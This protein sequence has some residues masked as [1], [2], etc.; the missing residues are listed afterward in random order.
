MDPVSLFATVLI[1][2][3]NWN[4]DKNA[5]MNDALQER[6]YYLEQE[7]V[8]LELKQESDML[9]LAAQQQK[10]FLTL[11]GKMSALA[12]EQAV[13]NQNYAD[14]AANMGKRIENLDEKYYYLDQKIMVLHP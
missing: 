1:F 6:I 8:E 11:A 13:V 3:M 2:G 9:A 12:A 14:E 7:V 10:D 5:Q 4:I